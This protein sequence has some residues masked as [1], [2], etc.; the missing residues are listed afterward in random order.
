MFDKIAYW[1]RRNN[2]D[3]AGNPKPLR[4]QGTLSLTKLFKHNPANISFDNE[5]RMYVNNRERRR[6]RVKLPGWS[7][8]TRH[9]I[10]KRERKALR[11]K[12]RR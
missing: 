8:F 2:K 12:G 5:G 6:R 4:G 7:V 11:K 3:A 1:Q 9:T 10:N